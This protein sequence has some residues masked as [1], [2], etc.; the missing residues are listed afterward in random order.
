MKKKNY[1]QNF[2]LH[3]LSSIMIP[4]IC[5]T[6]V[7]FLSYMIVYNKIYSLKTILLNFLIGKP[8]V[9][10]SWYITVIVYYYITFWIL[11]KICG[12]NSK[13][14]FLGEC[15]WY[16]LYVFIV[17]KFEYGTWYFNT[18]HLLIAGAFWAINEEK[19][20]SLIKALYKFIAPCTW[21]LFICLFPIAGK[22]TKTD[23]LISGVFVLS[24]LLFLMKFKLDSFIMSYL[25]R[26]SLEIYLIQGLFIKLFRVYLSV[27]QSEFLYALLTIFASVFVSGIFNYVSR[28]ALEK[29]NVFVNKI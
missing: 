22:N 12:K 23:V 15:L 19:L 14:M 18:C 16:I 13:L 5:I 29:F 4:F 24:I 8:I 26:I 6:I 7:Y 17:K 28:K 11:M 2:L 25:G 21:G 3:R 20:V 10:Y 1:S 9:S 27:I